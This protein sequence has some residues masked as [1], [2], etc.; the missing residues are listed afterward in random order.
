MIYVLLVLALLLLF[1]PLLTVFSV[2][3]IES[4]EHRVRVLECGD[5]VLKYLE[6]ALLVTGVAWFVLTFLVSP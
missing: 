4:A 1:A 6:C 3:S 5:S 2:D